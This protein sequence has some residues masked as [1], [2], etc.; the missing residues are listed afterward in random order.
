MDLHTPLL[1]SY[2]FKVFLAIWAPGVITEGIFDS[3]PTHFSESLDSS[4]TWKFIDDVWELPCMMFEDLN[5]PFHG[6]TG[7]SN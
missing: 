3:S 4:S 1:L 6:V 2:V 5:L 7:P